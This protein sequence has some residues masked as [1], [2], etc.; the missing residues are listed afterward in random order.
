MAKRQKVEEGAQCGSA[1][2]TSAAAVAA[3][4]DSDHAA[5]A[6]LRDLRQ[7]FEDLRDLCEA[8]VG[9][10]GRQQGQPPTDVERHCVEVASRLKESLEALI[11]RHK[12]T[13]DEGGERAQALIEKLFN[14]LQECM[15]T[16]GQKLD[17]MKRVQLDFLEDYSTTQTKPNCSGGWKDLVSYSHKLAFTTFAPP[18][19]IH[20]DPRWGTVGGQLGVGQATGHIHNSA[21]Y[22]QKWHVDASVLYDYS[23]DIATPSEEKVE[24]G[25]KIDGMDVDNRKEENQQQQTA[26][27]SEETEGN[28]KAGDKA[29]SNAAATKEED[30][31]TNHDEKPPPR[32]P[33]Q[34]QN[35]WVDFVLN[36][37]L[38]ELA[39]EEE[40]SES[41][42]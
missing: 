25:L 37:E 26:M 11:K 5:G 15:L 3:P 4:L 31:K 38:Q 24:A 28:G 16:L 8:S 12:Q 35:A 18:N 33:Q 40:F 7:C 10:E 39:S 27:K 22:P 6:V 14:K 23:R 17:L 29:D 19:Y 9:V 42:D 1:P 13:K 20:G 32:Q 34:T 36:P 21:P 41:S 2:S 30:A